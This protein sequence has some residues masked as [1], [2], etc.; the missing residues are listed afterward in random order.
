[1]SFG[2]PFLYIM[3]IKYMHYLYAYVIHLYLFK[4]VFLLQE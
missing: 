3:L 1:M 4:N 2:N